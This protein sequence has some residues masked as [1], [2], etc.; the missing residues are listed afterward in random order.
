[1]ADISQF[2]GFK[3]GS[4][5]YA[6][7]IMVIEEILRKTEIT[8]VPKAPDFIEGIVNIRGRVIPVVDLKKKLNL[9]TVNNSQTSR[10]II[11]NINN[12]KIGFL[13]D[14]VEEV[15]RIEKNLIEDAPALAVNID[16]NYINGVAKTDKGMIILLDITKVFSP[17]EQRQF[18]SI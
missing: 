17:Y 18:N 13:V 8:P 5:K 16:S 4:E 9:G 15:L 14:E 2:V 7:D 10:I 6:I 12:K 11:A 1:M 3:L